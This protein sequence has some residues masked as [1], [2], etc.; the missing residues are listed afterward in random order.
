VIRVH[1][2]GE[3]YHDQ[4]SDKQIVKID[5]FIKSVIDDPYNKLLRKT[6]T[7]D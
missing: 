7:A 5:C 1:I 6:K 2:R 3:E 4:P